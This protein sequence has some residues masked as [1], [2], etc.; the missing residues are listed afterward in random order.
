[1]WLT[2]LYF[3]GIPIII[4]AFYGVAKR[5]DASVWIYFIYLI[6]CFVID[7][8]ALIYLFMWQDACHSTGT[9]IKILGEDFGK[10][11]I[12]GVTR[13]GAWT[14]VLVAISME[15]YCLYIVWSFCEDVRRGTLI[16]T[17]WD[18]MNFSQVEQFMKKHA[19]QR[20]EHGKTD[21]FGRHSNDI[22]GLAHSKKP[23]PYP[24]PYGSFWSAPMTY[25]MSGGTSPVKGF[26][27]PTYTVFDGTEHDTNYPPHPQGPQHP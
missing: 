23:G 13:I 22:V 7:A 19:L 1:M 24:S 11:F 14:F 20:S 5:I 3:A 16:P 6:I 8:C 10:A 2:G 21:A 26:E 17:L 15:M 4:S 12:C 9:L 25:T 27:A 18:L